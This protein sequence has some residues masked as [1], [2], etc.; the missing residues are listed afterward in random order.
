MIDRLLQYT[1]TQGEQGTWGRKDRYIRR[2]K[3]RETKED[4]N[5]GGKKKGGEKSR[6]IRRRET[7]E[8]RNQ[9]GEKPRRKENKEERN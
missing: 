7:I 8:K 2:K 6:R 3:G 1:H 9:G 5:Q 4:R